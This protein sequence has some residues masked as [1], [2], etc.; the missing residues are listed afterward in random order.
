[1]SLRNQLFDLE[2]NQMIGFYMNYKTGLEWIRNLE[3]D[4]CLLKENRFGQSALLMNAMYIVFPYDD[5]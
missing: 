5:L 1:M 2:A 3:V 4:G